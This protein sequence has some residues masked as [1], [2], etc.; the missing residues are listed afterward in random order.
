MLVA[1]SCGVVN[2][3]P[4]GEKPVTVIWL[5]PKSRGLEEISGS[6]T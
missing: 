2:S 1:L 3:S 5:N 4:S 6:P